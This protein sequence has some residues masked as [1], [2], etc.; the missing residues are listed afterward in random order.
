[1]NKGFS[2]SANIEYGFPADAQYIVT[3]NG[4]KAVQNIINDYNSGIH[5]FTIIGTYGTGKSSFLLALEEDLKNTNK[6]K[7]LL[8]PKNLSDSSSFEFL[9]IVGDYTE[10]SVLLG[11]ALRS[12]G[13][14]QSILDR[15]KD[16]YNQ[17]KKQGK[18]LLIVIDE[19][20]KILEHTAKNNP[21]QELYFLQKLAEFV[22]VPTRE[23]LLLT[24][25]HQNFGAYS[26]NFNETQKNEW[27][28]VKG[29]FKEITFVE[30]IEQLLFLAARQI[31]DKR[32]E[33][34][35]KH[36]ESLF[37]L[38]IE[39]KF[40]SKYFSLETAQTLNPLDSFSAFAITAAIQR[41][42]QNERSLFSF[43]FARGSN[44]FSEFKSDTNLTYNLACVYDYITYNFYS[45]LKDANMDSMS[46]NSMQVAVE[47]VEGIDWDNEK[48]M[49]N[50]IKIV[51]SIGLLNLFGFASFM[52]DEKQMS[53]YAHLAMAIDD[54][55]CIINKLQK[56]RI[57]RYAKYKK[58]LLLFEGTDIDLELEIKKAGA[59]VAKPVSFIDDL[60]CFINKRISPVKAHYYHKGT[61]R[62]FSYEIR[63]NVVDM[64]PSGDIDGFIELVFS[65]KSNS[66]D[67][68]K[69]IS[70]ETDHA[71]IYVYFNDTEK[72][73][74]H[75]YSIKKYEYILTKVL[76]DRDADRVA[77][78][79][80]QKLKEHEE[81]LLNKSVL[82]ALFTYKNN[83][84]W[85]FNGEEQ[86]V[87]SHRDFN[88]LLSTVCDKVYSK[89][90]VMINELFNKHKLSSAISTARKNYLTALVNHYNEEDLGFE[91]E[92]FPPEKTI[93]Y[94]LLKSTG[95]HTG[96][97]F[98]DMPTGSI[99]ELWNECTT[100]LKSTVNRPRKISELIKKLSVQ[101]FKLK[102]GFIDFW[103]PTF[104]FIKRQDY[105]LYDA[106]NGAYIPNVDMLFF[107]LLQ[108][109]PADYS[110]KAFEVDGVKVDFFNQYR[111]LVK[112]EDEFSI[113]TQSFIDTIKPFLFFYKNLNE[114]TKQTRK[115]T[116]ISTMRFR[117][118]LANAKDPEMAFFEDL[119]DALGFNKNIKQNNDI[120]EYG[121]IIQEAIRELR[122]CYT[123]L[124]DRIENRLVDGLGLVSADYSEYITE[125][126]HRLSNIKLT[127]L[128]SKQ[129]EF[130]HHVM[131]EYDN[132]TLWFQ[133]ICYPILEHKLESLR[134]DEED[135]LAEDLV[136][137]FRSCEKYADI[138]KKQVADKDVAY[139]F[140][141]V[142]NIGTNI[143]TQTYILPE[144][145]KMRVAIQE[146]EI[147][148][149][150]S[151]N[152]NV[153][154]CTLL[155]ILNKKMNNKLE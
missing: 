121:N 43:L 142:S 35:R 134:D 140:D 115:F 26:R 127:L 39:T 120:E 86:S 66:I 97:G 112:L 137:L 7:K 136:Y 45:Y 3:P 111:R 71:V 89:T 33:K 56:F 138:S 83:V 153:D 135:K 149:L 110:I 60:R 27:A 93:Y 131:T 5:S 117:D 90:P 80:I 144:K 103:I 16:Y 65:V 4:E 61:P 51:K 143:R 73:I 92:K 12:D 74:D 42:G 59:I 126:R 15:L 116:H 29:R 62:Y 49:A 147:S 72:I 101:P 132:R 105:A 125:V 14:S 109:H 155:N 106:N 133:S 100:F 78:S 37:N 152:E 10:L 17:L 114:Y 21:E 70:A 139:S 95:L 118:V 52:M 36:I 31:N 76:I 150:L 64:V 75:L 63:D 23:I 19:F 107:D 119:P 47:R 34:H 28:K 123:Q 84:T 32:T 85:I 25:L 108:K 145:D 77:Y 96:T 6:E 38:A 68:I 46:W 54:A 122:S 104:L 69:T 79:E 41:Y 48:Q 113:T 40:I 1:M 44:S 20:G 11:R 151:G 67:S 9:N 57:I 2:L 128:T 87:L 81:V 53:A 146:E 91:R 129:K 18:F 141:L 13:N 98:S 82:E 8:N 88:R 102:Q 154:I 22:N 24:T 30:P 50:A 99:V 124:I 55:E 94:S 58:R 130:Y 148:K